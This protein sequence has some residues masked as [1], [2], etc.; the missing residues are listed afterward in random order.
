MDRVADPTRWRDPAILTFCFDAFSSREPGSTSLENAM[1]LDS[2]TPHTHVE[3]ARTAMP[4]MSLFKTDNEAA[5]LGLAQPLRHL[6][7]KHSPLRFDAR[8]ALAGND[9]DEA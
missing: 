2:R 4:D 6:T 7:A 9:Q 5:K 8:F 3:R 1:V